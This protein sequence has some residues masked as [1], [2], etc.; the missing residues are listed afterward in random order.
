MMR[1]MKLTRALPLLECWEMMF[2]TELPVSRDEHVMAYALEEQVELL[3]KLRIMMVR[4]CIKY[5][6]LVNF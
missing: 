4:F 6:W 5:F 1:L 3:S 2:Q